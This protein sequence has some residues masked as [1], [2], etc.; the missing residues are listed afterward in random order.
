MAEKLK[1]M[2]ES[3]GYSVAK[4][5]GGQEYTKEER[6]KIISDFRDQKIKVLITTDLLAR[7]IDI[8]TAKIV[9]NFEMPYKGNIETYL[10]RQGRVGRFGK[11]GKVISLIQSEEDKNVIRTLIN[12]YHA[13]FH[14][15]K[16][17]D[18]ETVFKNRK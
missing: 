7:G 11:N 12:D 6:K 3:K 18:I 14:E 5:T 15:I 9:I 16:E 4:I 2:L 1:K 10:H 8:P 17:S 13:E